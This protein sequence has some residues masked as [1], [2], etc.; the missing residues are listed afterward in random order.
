MPDDT[1]VRATSE[2]LDAAL[3][4]IAAQ[5]DP[6]ARARAREAIDLLLT[7]QGAAFERMLALAGDAAL[8]GPALVS[9]IADDPV[10]GPLLV[11]HGIHPHDPQTRVARTLDRVRPRMAASGCRASLV[12][13]DHGIA[14]VQ[15]QGRAKLG[16]ESGAALA[17]WLETALLE[18]APELSAIAIDDAEPPG[19]PAPALLQ[20]MRS[21]PRP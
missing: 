13:V 10:L 21:S 18:A 16:A 4:A 1:T 11:I 6:M 2:Q 3:Q 7:I 9:R 15:V 19:A 14:R 8:G 5:D 12:S 20:I 17:R